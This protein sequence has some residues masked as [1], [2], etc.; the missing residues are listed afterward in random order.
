[1]SHGLPT[2]PTCLDENP[3]KFLLAFSFNWPVR[4][5]LYVRNVS[6]ALPRVIAQHSGGGIASLDGVQRTVGK[7]VVYGRIQKGMR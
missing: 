1:M 6:G 2:V 4:R 7:A 5:P 3:F